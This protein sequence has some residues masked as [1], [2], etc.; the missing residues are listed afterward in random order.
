MSSLSLIS[1]TGFHSRESVP[2]WAY[3]AIPAMDDLSESFRSQLTLS[4]DD[5][6]VKL[7]SPGRFSIFSNA[8]RENTTKTVQ[9]IRERITVL[10]IGNG[11][12]YVAKELGTCF[13]KL[14]FS[15]EKDEQRLVQM[16]AKCKVDFQ[17]PYYRSPSFECAHRAEQIIHKLIHEWAYDTLDCKCGTKHHEWYKRDPEFVVTKFWL[18]YNWLVQQPYDME[19]GNLKPKWERA[20][21]SWHRSQ[22]AV[23][24]PGWDEFFLNGLSL[25]SVLIVSPIA[26]P[27]P[28]SRKSRSSIQMVQMSPSPPRPR[29]L[30]QANSSPAIL[31]HGDG[32]NDLP[33]N[34]A[35][36][37]RGCPSPLRAETTPSKIK[38]PTTPD[39]SSLCTPFEPVSFMDSSP[40][41]SKTT[42]KTVGAEDSAKAK[43][44]Y[45]PEAHMMTL[46]VAQDEHSLDDE[47]SEDDSDSDY[48][49]P[50]SDD[51]ELTEDEG[52]T[53]IEL[54]REGAEV[55]WEVKDLASEKDD[56]SD[57]EEK[58]AALK[59]NLEVGQMGLAD[60]KELSDE[61]QESAEETPTE[62]ELLREA[63]AEESEAEKCHTT[64]KGA[65]RE[66]KA[67]VK[68]NSFILKP[69]PI[70]FSVQACEK[71][72]MT[73]SAGSYR[74]SKNIGTGT[75]PLEEGSEYPCRGS[76]LGFSA[77]VAASMAVPQRTERWAKDQS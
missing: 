30:S 20:L 69:I 15:A 47:Q 63:R 27:S 53:E 76:L 46:A 57:E 58:L 66:T 5:P 28:K 38:N 13:I 40:S 44:G 11:T 17:M 65:V 48:R 62:D 67:S 21:R 2:S 34:R 50:L 51:E 45:T 61:E 12:V 14:G 42:I 24:P 77:P 25:P 70:S 32:S 9:K 1:V 49:V 39:A 64:E 43:V 18:V 16:M 72:T 33:P 68:Q 4:D 41:K 7:L 10:D 59:K 31:R 54:A 56:L 52:L 3:S 8:E 60:E 75:A 71:T 26:S 29:P 19:T 35:T 55:A 73:Q 37:A 6:P 36:S 74:G 22:N 23:A